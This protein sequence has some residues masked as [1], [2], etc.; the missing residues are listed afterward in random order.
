MDHLVHSHNAQP[1]NGILGE[2]L[3]EGDSNLMDYFMLY[4]LIYLIRLGA[5]HMERTHLLNCI[6]WSM[7][8]N[9]LLFLTSSLSAYMNPHGQL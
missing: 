2:I 9:R 8:S 1:R 7:S 3:D 5:K 4:L 6:R